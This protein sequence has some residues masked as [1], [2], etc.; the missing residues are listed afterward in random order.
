MGDWV[1]AYNDNI[2]VGAREWTGEYT[3]IPA[4]GFDDNIMTAGYCDDGD[5]ITFKL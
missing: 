3:D 1:I 5:E 4:M 2:V